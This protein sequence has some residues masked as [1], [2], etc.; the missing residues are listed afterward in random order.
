MLPTISNLKCNVL[1]DIDRI[2]RAR[3]P[4]NA[5]MVYKDLT[6]RIFGGKMQYKLARFGGILD[7]LLAA[8][9]EKTIG[10]FASD[11]MNTVMKS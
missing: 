8:K 2:S 11:W 5:E 3:T 6:D 4:Q 7:I 9:E 10:Q 1:M